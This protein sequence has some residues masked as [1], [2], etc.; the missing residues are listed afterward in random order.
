VYIGFSNGILLEG[1]WTKIVYAN[2]SHSAGFLTRLIFVKLTYLV[3]LSMTYTSRRKTLRIE[4]FVNQCLNCVTAQNKKWM[5]LVL[6][7]SKFNNSMGVTV[8]SLKPVFIN[9]S[10][11]VYFKLHRYSCIVKFHCC[12]KDA[13]VTVICALND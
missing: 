12:A 2:F 4:E 5:K 3:I 11:V 6:N 13:E 9:L 10:R 1:M 8:S 7:V